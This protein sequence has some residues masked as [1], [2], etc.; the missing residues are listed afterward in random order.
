MDDLEIYHH[1]IL[2]MKWGFRRFQNKDGTLTEEGK[3]RYNSNFSSSRNVHYNSKRRRNTDRM[4]NEELERE[5]KRIRLE[6]DY[7]RALIE[8]PKA[9][10]IKKTLSL[11]ADTTGSI[12]RT[13]NNSKNLVAIGKRIIESVME[14]DS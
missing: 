4:T 14:E 11:T 2:G 7:R 10:H 13:Y 5:I 1:G 12:I 6:N 3:K 8:A 9:H